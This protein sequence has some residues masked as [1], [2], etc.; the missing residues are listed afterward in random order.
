MKRLIFHS[1]VKLPGGYFRDHPTLVIALRSPFFVA[2][3][4]DK[5]VKQL[6]VLNQRLYGY[7]I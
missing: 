7:T 1:F 6:M 5:W 2:Y 3:P 4:I